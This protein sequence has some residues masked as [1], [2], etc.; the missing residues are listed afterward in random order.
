MSCIFHSGCV[1]P[2]TGYGITGLNGKTISAHKKA[3]VLAK[4][5]VPAGLVVRHTCH[6]K[7]CINPDH[8]IL[9]TQQDNINDKLAAGREARGS[10]VGGSKLTDEDVLKIRSL[11]GKMYQREIALKFNITQANVSLIMRRQTWTHLTEETK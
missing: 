5:S 11:R 2:V 4:G 3:Y 1:H 8:L 7:I 10:D 6:N 9:G